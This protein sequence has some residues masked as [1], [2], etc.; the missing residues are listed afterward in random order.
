MP[1]YSDAVDS[2]IN[3]LDTVVDNVSGT[4][5]QFQQATAQQV[6]EL[7]SQAS[8]FRRTFTQ[9]QEYPLEKIPAEYR[10]DYDKVM[11]QGR[12]I[13]NFL[14]AV[15]GETQNINDPDMQ[16][17]PLIVGAVVAAALSAVT[18]WLIAATPLAEN[19]ALVMDA[20]TGL[21]KATLP[22]LLLGSVLFFW[23]DIRRLF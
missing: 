9:L 7:R 21:A 2:A 17:A 1:W 19:L 5:T 18:A 12:L 16:A 6:S 8:N 3:Y 22:V 15:L 4:V 23:K 10:A 20:G 13:N 14:N 11:A